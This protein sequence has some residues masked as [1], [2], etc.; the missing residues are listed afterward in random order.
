M[1]KKCSI[2]IARR[3]L[4]INSVML[5]TRKKKTKKRYLMAIAI[6]KKIMKRC[7]IVMARRTRIN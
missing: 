5:M 6:R 7:P 2:V 4:I 1:G 3:N